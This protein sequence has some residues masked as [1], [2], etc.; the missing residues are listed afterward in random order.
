[1]SASIFIS[2]VASVFTVSIV[3]AWVGKLYA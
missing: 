1:V 2:T 3:I